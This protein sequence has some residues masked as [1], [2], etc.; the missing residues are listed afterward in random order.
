MSLTF[1]V[2]FKVSRDALGRGEKDRNSNKCRPTLCQLE[3]KISHGERKLRDSLVGET[4]V[5][6]ASGD[7]TSSRSVKQ[8]VT[9]RYFVGEVKISVGV[10]QDVDDFDVTV[11][12]GPVKSGTIQLYTRRPEQQAH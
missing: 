10:K 2:I 1:T 7:L 9:L 11:S 8:R 6:F 5:S 4:A 12:S 3:K